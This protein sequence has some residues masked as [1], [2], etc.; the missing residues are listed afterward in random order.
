LPG[1]LLPGLAQSHDNLIAGRGV[2]RYTV[3]KRLEEVAARGTMEIE[4]RRDFSQ[5]KDFVGVAAEKFK[6]VEG[7]MDNLIMVR[8]SVD[9]GARA[10][11][12]AAP[13]STLNSTL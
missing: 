1:D 10:V 6:D 4:K 2:Q 11:T 3:I 12:L 7:A 5:R 9:A 13:S 8:R